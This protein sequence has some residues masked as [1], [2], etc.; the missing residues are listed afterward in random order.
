M[1]DAGFVTIFTYAM[2]LGAD[3]ATLREAVGS[4][5]FIEVHV[6]TP[7]AVCKQR[8]DRGAYGLTHREPAYEVPGQADLS[9]DLSTQSV[10]EAAA[11][12]VSLLSQRGFLPAA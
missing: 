3:R 10:T 2:P 7:L 8:D 11:A 9:V 4:E 12:V 1:L 6:S 5:R